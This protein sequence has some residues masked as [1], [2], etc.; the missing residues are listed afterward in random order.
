MVET[1]NNQG[2]V[3]Q[4]CIFHAVDALLRG[5][6][7]IFKGAAV[8]DLA[9]ISPQRQATVIDYLLVYTPQS[10]VR[11]ARCI[12]FPLSHFDIGWTR[13]LIKCDPTV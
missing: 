4:G 2:L 10:E 9:E 11:H 7:W 12:I 3:M 13:F 1:Y 5:G 8:G 6:R